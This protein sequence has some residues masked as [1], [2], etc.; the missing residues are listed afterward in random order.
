MRLICKNLFTV[1]I[2]LALSGCLLIQDFGKRWD[3]AK[4]DPCLDDIVKSLYISEFRRDLGDKDIQDVARELTLHGQNYILVKKHPEDKGGRLYRFTMSAGK[5]VH[6]MHV[7]FQ[8]WRLNPTMRETFMRDYPHSI[9]Q[10]DDDTVTL[11][12]LEGDSEKLLTEIAEK[13]EYWQIEEQTL[14]NRVRDPK[15]RFETRDLSPAEDKFTSAK[16]YHLNKPSYHGDVL[17][18]TAPKGIQ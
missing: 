10:V 4:T 18:M 17:P 3:E 12:N 5:E 14:Y 16:R 11:P 7:V 2:L 8:R 15:C 6:A 13:P 1:C 9:A